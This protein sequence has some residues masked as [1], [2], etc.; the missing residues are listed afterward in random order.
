MNSRFAHLIERLYE[1]RLS[2]YSSPVK[3]SAP[4]QFETCSSPIEFSLFFR[5]RYFQ[6]IMETT[7]SE[8]IAIRLKEYIADTSHDALNLRKLAARF[9]V[10]PLCVDW[11]NCWAIRSDGRV[12]VFL[13]STED[14]QPEIE[15]D[16][17]LV[18]I[19][20]YQG[21]ITYPEIKS[22]VPSRPAQSKDCP[23]CVEKGIDPGS[24][25]DENI[26]CYCGGLGWVPAV[27]S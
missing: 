11:E 16:Q 8:Q 21:G 22:L 4:L 5:S 12:V 17:R 10:L 3:P 9:E 15:D 20:L 18:N 27:L 14:T 23:Y 25:E 2:G 13:H 26:I 7:L 24:L 1:N 6:M 19:A